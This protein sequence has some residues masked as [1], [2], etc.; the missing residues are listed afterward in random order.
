[1]WGF[2]MKEDSTRALNYE[3]WSRKKLIAHYSD[4]GGKKK[5]SKK[6]SG[7]NILEYLP[8]IKP[9]DLGSNQK[10][11][12]GEGRNQ[13]SESCCCSQVNDKGKGNMFK[14]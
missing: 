14:V 6:G 4:R 2:S 13:L 3:I 9:N 8:D 10:T 5:K 1:M 12:M 11:H 7:K